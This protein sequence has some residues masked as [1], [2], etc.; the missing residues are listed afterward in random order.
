MRLPNLSNKLSAFTLIEVLIVV[1]IM[2]VLTVAA[3]PSFGDFADRRTFQNNVD[4]FA[5]NIRSARNKALDGVVVLGRDVNWQIIP[6]NN[7]AT[8]V[9]KYLFVDSLGGSGTSQTL[10]LSGSESKFTCTSCTLEF[11]RLTGK[12]ISGT[13]GSSQNIVISFNG[14]SKTIKVYETGKMVIE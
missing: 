4:I 7:S 9:V 10:K 11:Q 8:Y 5:E 13:L 6:T 1:G 3:L 12:R 2:G 14:E